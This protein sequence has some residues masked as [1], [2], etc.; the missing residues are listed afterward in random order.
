MLKP[1]SFFFQAK[2]MIFIFK[3]IL[4]IFIFSITVGLQGSVNFLLYSKVTQA[5]IHIYILFLTLSSMPLLGIYPDKTFLEK[6]TCPYVHCGTIHN[7]QDMETTDDWI[8]KMWY[9][10]T[11]EYYCVCKK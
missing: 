4:M 10:Y 2:R 1:T 3:D 7:N 11:M 8:K 5:H 6:D 9:T